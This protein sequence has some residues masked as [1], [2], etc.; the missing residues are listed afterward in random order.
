MKLIAW[1]ACWGMATGGVYAVA[2]VDRKTERATTVD[3]SKEVVQPRPETVPV[4][5]TAMP[6]PNEEAP[7]AQPTTWEKVKEGTGEAVD[8]GIEKTQDLARSLGKTYLRREATKWSVTGNYSLFE[9]WVLTKYG[10]TVGYNRSTAST[11]ELEYM[12]G[13]IGFGYFGIDLGE[14]SE[15]RL[16]VRWRS[17]NKRNSFNFTTG[18]YYNWIDVHLGSDLLSSVSGYQAKVDVME[19]QTL[20]VS[21]G[22]G[23]RW[24]TSGGFVWGADWLTIHLPLITTKQEHP[25]IDASNSAAARDDAQDAL[26]IFRRIPSLAA[27]K[28]QLGF[29]F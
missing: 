4:E 23:N 11:Y 22:L 16:A 9:M 10:F 3:D 7:A 20:G 27:L 15:Q 24:Q 2:Q 18:L 13:S 5:P 8:Y 17:Y 29:S 6:S 1:L 28:I 19:L 25:F 21:W 14:I 26:K 12:K